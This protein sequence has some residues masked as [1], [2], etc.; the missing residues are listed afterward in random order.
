MP[1]SCRSADRRRD[2][3]ENKFPI[4]S[5]NDLTGCGNDGGDFCTHML[6]HEMARSCYEA[7]GGPKGSAKLL[8][9]EDMYNIYKAAL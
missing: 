4:F 2:R 5:H 1:S 8:Y 3:D 9:E 6:E 7:C